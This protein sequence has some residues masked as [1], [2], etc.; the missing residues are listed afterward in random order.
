[1]SQARILVADTPEAFEIF[2]ETLTSG[3]TLVRASTLDEARRALHPAPSLV[4]CGCHFDEGRMYDLL[5][6]VKATPG[7]G[8]VPFMAVR[9]IEGKLEDALY[10]SVKIAVRALGGNAFVD[11]LRW[12]QRWGQAEAAH[13]LTHLV[14]T[15]ASTG[16]A[17][18]G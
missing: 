16:P 6:L 10:E 12:Q 17:D 15:L 2:R 18:T 3:F 7:T 9:C 11:L 8:N 1:M 5:R 14:Q 13:R 4:V